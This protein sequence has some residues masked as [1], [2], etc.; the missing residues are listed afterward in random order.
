MIALRKSK[1]FYH[2]LMV[3]IMK[4]WN[5]AYNQIYTKVESNLNQNLNNIK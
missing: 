2:S 5:W 4:I 3:K 1:K